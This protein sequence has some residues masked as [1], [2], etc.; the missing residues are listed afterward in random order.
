MGCLRSRD[1]LL[2]AILLSFGTVQAPVDADLLDRKYARNCADCHGRLMQGSDAG[3]PLVDSSIRRGESIEQI[4]A[5]ISQPQNEAS[6]HDFGNRLSKADIRGLAILIAEHRQPAAEDDFGTQHEIQLPA[7]VQVTGGTRFRIETVAEDIGPFPFS[8][9]PLPNGDILLTEKTRGLSI[10]HPDGSRTGPIAGTPETSDS[11]RVRWGLLYGN[12]WLLDVAPHPDY[13]QNGWIYLHHT[14]LCSQCRRK[15]WLGFFVKSMNRVV[16]GRIRDG[17]WVD[18]QVVWHSPE[19]FYTAKPDLAAG[20]RLAFDTAGYVFIGIGLTSSNNRS[21]QELDTPF[22]KVLRLHDDGRIPADNPFV[23]RNGALPEIWTLGHRV[24]QGLEFDS[25]SESL[26]SSEMGPRGGD[27]INS[28]R[29]GGNYG[30]PWHSDGVHYDGSPVSGLEKAGLAAGDIEFAV[31]DF[32]PSPAISS[33]IVYSG[34]AFP[35]WHGSF[36]V[37]SLKAKTLYRVAIDDDAHV[38]TE[39]LLEGIG[40]IRDIEAGPDGAVF[41]LL[42]SAKGSMVVKLVPD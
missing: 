30:W 19:R 39:I 14:D 11:G 33:F 27:E 5:G 17:R 23:N 6:E 16:R 18:Q 13:A 31:V 37:G 41:L 7:E 22:G 35:A 29:S 9:A 15:K 21:A 4:I 24:P 42:E 3:P 36:L 10:I 34:T 26:W 2:L 25:S 40:R 8:V 28:L 20:G 1:S 38:R 32:T 12:G